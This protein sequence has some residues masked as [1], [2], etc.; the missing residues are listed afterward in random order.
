[1]A[2]EALA[3]V[4]RTADSFLIWVQLTAHRN[5][6]LESVRDPAPQPPGQRFRIQLLRILHLDMT[7]LD[8]VDCAAPPNPDSEAR[9]GLGTAGS[10]KPSNADRVG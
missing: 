1:M 9:R 4:S 6:I 3:T 10:P 8:S 5:C 2:P 7:P